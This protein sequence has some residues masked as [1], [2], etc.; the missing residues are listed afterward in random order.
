[1]RHP[2]T[3]RPVRPAIAIAGL[4][5]AMLLLI[6]SGGTPGAASAAAQPKAHTSQPYTYLK[7]RGTYRDTTVYGGRSWSVYRPAVTE[8]WIAADGS[9]RQRELSL[10]PKFVSPADKQ[11]WED[12]GKPNFLAKGFRGH[13]SDEFF[14]AGSFPD[15]LFGSEMLASMPSAPAEVA[16]WLRDRV[17][18]PA[19]GGAGNGFPDSVKTIELVTDLLANPLASPA[20]RRALVE[21]EA[22][23]PGVEDLGAARDEAGRAGTRIGARSGNSGLDSVYSLIFDPGTSQVLAGE[24]RLATPPAGDESGLFASTVYLN[25]GETRSRRARPGRVQRNR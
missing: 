4:C 2:V 15:R 23:V 7:T 6:P 8:R 10:A 24:I 14:P 1:M 16:A 3:I 13:V 22:L 18:D 11:A 21:G 5:L 9:G 17:H 19:F 20:Q 12:A 25:E